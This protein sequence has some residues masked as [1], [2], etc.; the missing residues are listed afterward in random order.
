[1]AEP[2]V[3]VDPRIYGGDAPTGHAVPEFDPMGSAPVQPQDA[4]AP[5]RVSQEQIGAGTLSAA[6]GQNQAAMNAREVVSGETS[7][8]AAIKSWSP[9]RVWD[10]VNMPH[11][12]QDPTFDPKP[13]INGVRFVMSEDEQ[14]FLAQSKSL[15]EFQYR[16]QNTE[17]QRALYQQ[18]GDHPWISTVVGFA[19]PGY[20]ALD[21]ASAGVAGVAQA[22]GMT[23]RA[24]R[25]TAGLTAAGS[26]YGLGV[27]QSQVVPMSESEIILPAL[28]SG[29]ASAMFYRPK[30]GLVHADPTYPSDE[31]GRAAAAI[32]GE[33]VGVE[34]RVVAESEDMAA[35]ARPDLDTITHPTRTLDSITLERFGVQ[36]ETRGVTDAYTMLA[37]HENDA[38]FGP[39][40]RALREEQ[41]AA[42]QGVRVVDADVIRQKMPSAFYTSADHSIYLH[43]MVDDAFTTLHEAVHSL[44]TA[45]LE[46]GMANPGTA[47]GQIVQQLELLR[48]QVLD[49]IQKHPAK[50]SFEQ[51]RSNYFS[52]DVHE[53][54]AG[55][56][57]GD[58][59][60]AQALAKLP[61]QGARNALSKVVDTVRKLLGIA[62]TQQTALNKRWA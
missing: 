5:E 51:F 33:A 50:E 52:G 53:F 23:A 46:Y 31:L 19:D 10:Y 6:V 41:G 15:D 43:P 62:P 58:T 24:A 1:M 3:N 42:L 38:T 14:K 18:M 59:H 37:K 22:A 16:V 30:K 17:Q 36:G 9:M 32:R 45:K 8:L 7:A 34:K 54:V 25:I 48:D 61:A 47:H 44:T 11:F 39:M 12:D 60:F 13:Y 49:A 56:F 40:I 35:V 57:S 55:L 21:L 29:A 4:P 28:M 26:T 20:L 27:A 2:I